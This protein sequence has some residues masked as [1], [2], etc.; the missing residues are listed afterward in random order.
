MLAAQRRADCHYN[1]A[2]AQKQEWDKAEAAYKKAI[3]LKAD[4]VD[5]YNGHAVV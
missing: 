4:H 2:Y 1:I 3:E 5:A